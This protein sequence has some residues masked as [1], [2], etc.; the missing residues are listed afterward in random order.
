VSDLAETFGRTKADITW[1]ITVVLMLRSVGAI[2]FG[3]AGDRYGRK[4]PFI[5]SNLLFIVFELVSLFLVS[6]IF[7]SRR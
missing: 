7:P 4:W 1:G 5:L 2:I 6:L 3:L